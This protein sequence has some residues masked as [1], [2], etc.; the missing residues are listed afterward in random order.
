MLKFQT[1]E[2]EKFHLD[3]IKLSTND[4]IELKISYKS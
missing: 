2:I 1:K 3:L 4:D